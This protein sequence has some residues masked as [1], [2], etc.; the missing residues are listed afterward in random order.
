MT[1]SISIE[2][3]ENNMQDKKPKENC[4][5]YLNQRHYMITTNFDA[6]SVMML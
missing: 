5:H 6:Q 3:T 4:T 1:E 2:L